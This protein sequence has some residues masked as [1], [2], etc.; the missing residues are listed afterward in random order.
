MFSLQ[1]DWCIWLWETSPDSIGVWCY[2]R[3]NTISKISRK[4]L[5]SETPLSLRVCG[6]VTIWGMLTLSIVF[7]LLLEI[8]FNFMKLGL[9]CPTPSSPHQPQIIWS[10]LDT[11][12]KLGQ[13]HFL[14]ETVEFEFIDVHLG[15]R[16]WGRWEAAFWSCIPEKQRKLIWREK[17]REGERCKEKQKGVYVQPESGRGEHQQECEMQTVML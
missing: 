2:M 6:P 4:F 11:W 14:C 8:V 3:H 10:G 13:S 1:K 16:D 9:L 7:L 15:C 12:P 5:N 17:E